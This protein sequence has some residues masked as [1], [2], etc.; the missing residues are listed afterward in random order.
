MQTA[1]TALAQSIAL[2]LNSAAIIARATKPYQA[3]VGWRSRTFDTIAERADYEMAFMCFP[4]PVENNTA[5]ARQGW[6]DAEK[7]FEWRED[8]RA[9][10]EGALA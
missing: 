5:A 4:Q 9:E 3:R 8:A 1:E 10:R 6:F 7:S 2:C